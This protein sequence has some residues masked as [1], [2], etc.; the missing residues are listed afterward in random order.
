V[1]LQQERDN[2]NFDTQEMKEWIF[3]GKESLE[4][5]EQRQNEL[6]KDPIM[7]SSPKYYEMTRLEQIQISYQRV[8]KWAE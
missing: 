1:D 8:K 6:F 4:G 5:Y 2:A 3:E 7:R